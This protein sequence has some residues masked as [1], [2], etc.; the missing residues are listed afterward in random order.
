M[1][2]NN[3]RFSR[4]LVNDGKDSYNGDK[5]GLLKK[6]KFQQRNCNEDSMQGIRDQGRLNEYNWEMTL[7][8]EVKLKR[9]FEV[10]RCAKVY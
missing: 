7:G 2:P 4:K 1:N 6:Q 5:V 8:L 9:L 10:T 3:G